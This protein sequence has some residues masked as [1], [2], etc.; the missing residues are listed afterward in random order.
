MAHKRQQPDPAPETVTRGYEV[1]DLRPRWLLIA[2]TGFI[3]LAIVIHLVVWFMLKGMA[4]DVRKEDI[5]RSVVTQNPPRLEG[6]PLQPTQSHDRLPQED[7]E[8]MRRR[9]DQ[10]FANL[11]WT[12]DGARHR[13]EPPA[14]L[15][16]AVAARRPSQ[17]GSQ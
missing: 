17:G 4:K 13:V 3:A 8:Q 2:V 11:G 15:V 12:V 14:E 1:G 10:V 9:E 7:L 6:P 16:R 5:P